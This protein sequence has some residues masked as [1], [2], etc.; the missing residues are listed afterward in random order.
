MLILNA[1]VLP[2]FRSSAAITEEPVQP[3]ALNGDQIIDALGTVEAG[4]SVD[5]AFG[6]QPVEYRDWG[7]SQNKIFAQLFGMPY[8]YDDAVYVLDDETTAADQSFTV[9]GAIITGDEFSLHYSML[10][11]YDINNDPRATPEA[12]LDY[13]NGDGNFLLFVG[14]LSTNLASVPVS[15]IVMQA[16]RTADQGRTRM[17]LLFGFAD[18]ETIDNLDA[19]NETAA[20]PPGLGPD[21]QDCELAFAIAMADH[22][23]AVT[24]ASNDFNT[25][26][27]DTISAVNFGIGA[28]VALGALTFLLTTLSGPAAV[29]G[30]LKVGGACVATA[31]A[32]GAGA[33][34]LCE[35]SFNSKMRA[36]QSALEA[37]L[38]AARNAFGSDCP[39][40]NV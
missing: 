8:N 7:T 35:D 1:M 6:P 40:I 31:L 33:M 30:A 23:N 9:T 28:C 12:K 17:L 15:G 36:A 16:T 3:M 20:G 4:A 27:A 34:V 14:T 26:A 2:T 39:D 22:A 19:I 32:L 18:Q 11:E 10:L 13:A 25:C 37:A 24:N 21:L 29:A 5:Q 38:Q